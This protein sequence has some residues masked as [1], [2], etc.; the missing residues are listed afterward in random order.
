[1]K[2]KG[3]TTGPMVLLILDGFGL[4][5]QTAGNAIRLAKIPNWNALWKKFPHTTLQASGRAVGLVNHQD[6]NSEAGHMNIGA[7]RVVEQDPVRINR[8][9]R[10]GVFFKNPAFLHAI[11]HVKKHQ[12]ALHL[13]GM[14]GNRESAHAYP[15]HLHALLKLAHQEGIKKVYLHLFTDGRDSPPHAAILLIRRLRRFMYPGQQIATLMGRYYG[16]ER[17]KRWAVTEQAYDTLVLGGKKCLSAESAED[18][19][20]QAYNRGE[21]DEFIQPTV[22]VQKGRI[23]SNDSVIFF[24]LRSDRARQ[25]TKTFVQQNFTHSN[26]GSFA[27]KKRLHKVI[28]VTMTDFGP[29]LDH[30]ISAFPAVQIPD[31]LPL[32]LS[33]VRQLFIA[34][35]EK[36]AHVTYFINGGYAD[37]VNGEVRIKVDSPHTAHYD[38]TPRMSSKHITDIVIKYLQQARFDFFCVNLAN[39]DMVAHT[40]NLKAT[41]AAVE[42]IDFEIGRLYTAVK[43]AKGTLVITADHGN[44]EEMITPGTS[45]VDTEHSTNPVPFLVTSKS[46]RF[47]RA[48]G[49]LADIAPTLLSLLGIKIPKSMTGKKLI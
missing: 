26:P 5:P 38:L 27:L 29:D 2:P 18:A 19:I 21:T 44:A 28:F 10:E 25:I 20:V 17:A 49:T 31:S 1:M 41:V 37:P 9:I 12:S 30:V 36:Y 33:E 43:Q 7:G 4:S 42:E 45:E 24:N 8:A 46:V 39:A 16:M 48:N 13:M 35:S 34:E 6:G 11:H 14:L 47:S 22:L 3:I 23:K 40:G 15:E 32:A